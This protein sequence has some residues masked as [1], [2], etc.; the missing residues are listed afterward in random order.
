MVRLSIGSALALA[1]LL[2]QPAL[3][4]APQSGAQGSGATQQNRGTPLPAAP[5]PMPS[6]QVGSNA[7]GLSQIGPAP[8][9]PPDPRRNPP[10]RP[11]ALTLQQ[12]L[13]LARAG[14]PALLAARQNLE[15]TRAQEIQA[16]VRQNPN[17]GLVGQEVTLG[18]H[19]PASPYTYSAQVSRLFERGQKRRWRLNGARATTQQTED[20]LHDQERGTELAVKQAFTEM[21]IAKAAL[22]L[23]NANLAD[24]RREVEI[25]NDRYKAG[26]IGKLDYERL[27]LQL[28]QF[29]SDHSAAEINLRQASDQLQTLLG[30][31]SPRPDFDVAGEIVP[32]DLPL[33]LPGLDAKALAARPDYLAALAGVS[34]ADAN[35]KLAYANG[36]SDPTLEGEYERSAIY[37]TFGYNF[38]IPVRIFDKNQ[39]NKKTSEFAA[40]GSRFT[41]IAARNQVLSDVDQAWIGYTQSRALSARYSSHYLDEAGDVLSIAQFAYEHGGIALIDYLDALR[42]SRQTTADALQAYSATWLA[43]HQISYAAATEVLP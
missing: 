16:G 42:D 22:T 4:Q 19:N 37:N 5:T 6:A 3:A 7:N 14:N 21:L 43:I 38:Q 35:V 41:V 28:A 31:E 30:I 40:Q 18:Q 10:A 8:P 17:F 33:D 26:D 1:A 27:D 32:P 39:G 11:G 20:Q 29:E 25:N 24:F 12:V 9:S 36:T 2:T 15:A 34:V 13:T 23:S